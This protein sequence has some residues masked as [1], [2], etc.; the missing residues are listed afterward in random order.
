MS[1]NL[2]FEICSIIKLGNKL[3]PT[4]LGK[5]LMSLL[6]CNYVGGRFSTLFKKRQMM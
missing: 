1:A 2:A 3:I 5:R 6:F 4:R